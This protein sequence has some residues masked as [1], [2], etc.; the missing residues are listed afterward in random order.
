VGN[1]KNVF[2]A[3]IAAEYVGVKIELTPSFQIGVTNTTPE[4]LKLNPLGKV[5]QTSF[6]SLIYTCF[7]AVAKSKMLLLMHTCM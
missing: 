1:N 5:Q 3:L 7:P 6:C 4:F 2:K